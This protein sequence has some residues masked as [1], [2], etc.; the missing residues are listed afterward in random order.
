M[1][2]FAGIYSLKQG[3]H[4]KAPPE[5]ACQAIIRALSRA[6]DPLQVA[7]YGRFFLAKI[8]IGAF[9]DRA[10]HETGCQVVATLAGHPYLQSHGNSCGSREEALASLSAIRTDEDTSTFQRCNGSFAFCAYSAADGRLLLATDRLGVRPV[11]YYIGKEYLYFSTA[12]RILECLDVIPRVMDVGAI[13]EMIALGYPLGNRTPYSDIKILEDGQ[14]LHSQNKQVKIGEYSRLDDIPLAGSDEEELTG[15]VYN[16][17]ADAISIRRADATSVVSLLSGGLDSRCIVSVLKELGTDVRTLTFDTSGMDSRIAEKYAA[18][19]GSRHQ[20][21]ATQPGDGEMDLA[22][23][24]R[25]VCWPATSNDFNSKLVF[26]GD[27]GSVGV[28]GVYLDEEMIRT[29]RSGDVS[30]VARRLVGSALPKRLFRQGLDNVLRNNLINSVQREIGKNLSEDPGR[31]I[32]LFFMRNDQRRHLHAINEAIDE[33]RIEFL[34]P[35]F[36]GSLLDALLSAPV[37]C[38]LRHQFYHSWLN[39]FPRDVLSVPWQTYP[40]HFPCPLSAKLSGRSQWE[41]TS[42]ERFSASKRHRQKCFRHLTS[43]TFPAQFMNRSKVAAAFLAHS[44]RIRSYEYVFRSVDLL[45]RY[46][47]SCDGNVDWPN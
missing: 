32:H 28:G 46:Y 18:A 36:H 21:H 17:F 23:N 45:A 30:P 11:Y 33:Y 14:F 39:R 6:N 9:P 44:S 34:T 15:R 31:N 25:D 24:I 43:A 7:A 22:R 27:G 40:G 41:R 2:L 8:D 13:A 5:P 42:K 37:D 20:L 1:S 16:D 4:G 38:F 35:F 29:V 26:S 47:S 19:I 3:A 12:L 10:F